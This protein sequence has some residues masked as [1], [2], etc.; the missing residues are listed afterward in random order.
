MIIATFKIRIAGF[1]VRG[2]RG[3]AELKLTCSAV[4]WTVKWN[5]YSWASQQYPF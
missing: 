1:E 4:K 3:R 5:G 2:L